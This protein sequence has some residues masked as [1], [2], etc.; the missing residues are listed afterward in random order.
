MVSCDLLLLGV[1]TPPIVDSAV[2]G[3]QPTTDSM[4]SLDPPSPPASGRHRECGPLLNDLLGSSHSS[5]HQLS[6]TDTNSGLCGW[7][8]TRVGGCP[9]MRSPALT[10][11]FLFLLPGS[12]LPLFP[13]DGQSGQVGLGLLCLPGQV[14]FHVT[15]FCLLLLNLFSVWIKWCHRD[16]FPTTVCQTGW[17]SE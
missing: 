17:E 1:V 3:L 9:C 2:L 5:P 16:I 12:L 13:D 8:R 15:L 11:P 10:F 4:M 14:H 7:P 6:D